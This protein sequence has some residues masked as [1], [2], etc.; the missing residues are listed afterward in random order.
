MN[1]FKFAPT[2]GEAPL[3]FGY[4]LKCKP[5]PI[6]VDCGDPNDPRSSYQIDTHIYWNTGIYNGNASF[7]DLDGN[8]HNE[9]FNVVVSLKS[10]SQI[11]TGFYQTKVATIEGDAVGFSLSL[12]VPNNEIS[13]TEWIWDDGTTSTYQFADLPEAINPW[14]TYKSAGIFNGSVTIYR[15][16]NTSET[17]KFSVVAAE[18]PANNMDIAFIIQTKQFPT[19]KGK[20]VNFSINSLGTLAGVDV[21]HAWW[22]M[23]NGVS[24]HLIRPD[25]HSQE[26]DPH[27]QYQDPLGLAYQYE[28]KGVYKVTCNVCLTNGRCYLAVPN[29]IV[30]Q[31]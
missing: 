1:N 20:I 23:G 17:K 25:Q 13:K 28:R 9:K 29:I 27:I 4:V 11:I 31:D 2:T 21:K 15:K 10:S 7:T 19:T 26:Q 16:N 14:H 3:Y 30:V 18:N 12:G 22:H 24:F 8:N 5:F 6:D